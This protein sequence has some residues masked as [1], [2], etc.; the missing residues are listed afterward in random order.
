MNG[1]L[2]AAE[3]TEFSTFSLSYAA[4]SGNIIST[5]EDINSYYHALFQSNRLLTTSQF[6]K[7]SSWVQDDGGENP[8]QPIISPNLAK[9][10]D[11]Y[12]LGIQAESI[13]LSP[14]RVI[15]YPN[16]A[17]HIDNY[18]FAYYYAGATLGFSFYYIYNPKTSE[19]VVIGINSPSVSQGNSDILEL[20][21][22]LLNYL[23]QQCTLN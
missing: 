7:I 3:P 12:G 10:G 1:Y 18:S 16:L 14:E 8:G 15:N 17:K 5:T 23:D 4:G 2:S 20:V 9:N 21:Y 11:G 6:Q 22:S 13:I 19:Y